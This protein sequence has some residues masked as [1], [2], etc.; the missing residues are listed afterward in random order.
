MINWD[1]NI[2]RDI[3]KRKCVIFIGSG[4]SK[5]S[6]N[7]TGDRPEDWSEL[8]KSFLTLPKFTT[9][10]IKEINALIRSK[11]YLTACELIK[12]VV[13]TQ[14]FND[15]LRKKFITPKFLAANIH[16]H[17]YNLDS[18][19]VATPNFDKIY[20]TYATKTSEGTITVKK[21]YDKDIVEFI[22]SHESFIL[23]IHGCIDSPNQLIFTRKDYAKSRN[24]YHQFYKIL[25][26]LIITHTFIF[27]GCGVN[28][29][30]IRLLLE[31]N[32]F[33][34]EYGRKHYIIVPNK[35]IT[36]D[37]KEILQETLNLNFIFYDS[38]DNHKQLTDSLKELVE[39]VE[40]ERKSISE[41]RDW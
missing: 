7:N 19:I 4:V 11:D 25:E 15:F 3:A 8:L 30:D 22:R 32:A 2:I 9:A 36:S 5:N 16:E 26:A 23:K 28:D 38:S 29:P 24:E 20:D 21:Y 1:E 10:N 34:F 12:K 27:V 41:K 6:T 37:Q 31:N 39:L 14:H 13:G 35:S 18:R 40:G 17:I 33:S